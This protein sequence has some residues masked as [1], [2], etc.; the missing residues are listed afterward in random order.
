MSSVLKHKKLVAAVL[1]VVLIVAFGYGAVRLWDV[2]HATASPFSKQILSGVAFPLYYPSPL[3]LGYVLDQKSIGSNGSTAYYQLVNPAKNILITITMQ[4]TPN[5]FDAAKLT[6]NA[7]IPT[8]IV[9]SGTVYNLS[10]GGSSKYMFTTGDGTLI[11]ITSA[12]QIPS[13]DISRLTTS[14]KKVD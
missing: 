11:F 10:I 3:P 5:K 4:P 12:K 6:A 9:P 8:T 2:R 7:S 1:A 13:E 14:L